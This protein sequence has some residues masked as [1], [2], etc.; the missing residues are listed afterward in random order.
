M[1][2]IPFLKFIIG[3]FSMTT[4]PYSEASISLNGRFRHALISDEVFLE[5]QNCVLKTF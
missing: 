5:R 3:P 1:A 4:F 2:T